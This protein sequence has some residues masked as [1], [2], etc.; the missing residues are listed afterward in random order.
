MKITLATPRFI[1]SNIYPSDAGPKQNLI[2]SGLLFKSF[3]MLSSEPQRV[4][5]ELE[6]NDNVENYT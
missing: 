2:S 3:K 6:D 1:C 5:G 4:F